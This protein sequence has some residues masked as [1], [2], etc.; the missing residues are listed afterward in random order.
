MRTII[1]SLLLS[2]SCWTLWSQQEIEV[3]VDLQNTTYSATATT[4]GTYYWTLGPNTTAQGN[5]FTVDWSLFPL[6]TYTIEL[7][8]DDGTNCPALPVF[9][10]VLLYDCEIP[11]VYISNTFTPDNDNFNQTFKPIFTS[12]FDPFDY[13]L[14]I[15]NRWGEIIFE[16]HDA[17]V[18]W[19]GSYG[20]SGEVGV[21][22]DGVYTWKIEF[23]A[24]SNDERRMVIGHVNVLR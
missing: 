16:S 14:L 8:F 17:T 21:V 6:G 1:F 11:I 5:T 23:K 13:T 19:D 24:T 20:N 2:N 15:F 9:Y 3:C 18:G 12:G 4:E 7:N 10:I 22:Q